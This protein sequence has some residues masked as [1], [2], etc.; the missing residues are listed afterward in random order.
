M[1]CYLFGSRTS[2]REELTHAADRGLRWRRVLGTMDWR[3]ADLLLDHEEGADAEAWRIRGILAAAGTRTLLDLGGVF[4]IGVIL[5][6]HSAA[7]LRQRLPVAA[8]SGPLRFLGG[9]GRP[10]DARG[11]EAD[12]GGTHL[13][14]SGGSMRDQ[15]RGEDLCAHGRSLLAA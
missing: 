14:D 12:A 5:T 3:G 9:G 11:V 2:L 1:Y 4:V 8:G 15:G 13:R 7:A 6:T 10:R